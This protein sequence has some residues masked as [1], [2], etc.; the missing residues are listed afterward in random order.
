M[1]K[2]KYKVGDQVRVIDAWVN[3]LSDDFKGKVMTVVQD[4]IEGDKGGLFVE[5]SQG[6]QW[7]YRDAGVEL[8]EGPW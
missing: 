7:W 4:Y 3:I 2:S 5:V 6:H 1:S 8:A